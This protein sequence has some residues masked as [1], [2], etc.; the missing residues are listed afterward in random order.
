MR[1]ILIS[2][3]LLICISNAYSQNTALEDFQNSVSYNLLIR[4]VLM[5]GKII[6]FD[7][8]KVIIEEV[9]GNTITVLH[10][11][12]Q[13]SES[14]VNVGR[15]LAIKKTSKKYIPNDHDYALAFVDFTA[16]D[17]NST[18]VLTIYD[19]NWDNYVASR[20]SLINGEIS[21]W[22]A[23]GI[24]DEIKEKYGRSSGHFCDGNK[25]GDVSW[26]ECYNCMWNTCQ[27]DPECKNLCDFADKFGRPKNQCKI[28]IAASCVW[29]A[30][31][32]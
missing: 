24:P 26:G 16:V 31:V 14:K 22:T 4:N 32:Y 5:E 1:K 28:S 13:N 12:I 18:G 23:N 27:N 30:A 6:N 21:E 11:F 7:S 3:F 19:I 25:N 10:L 29:L 15:I 17:K 8:S 9:N 20:I 2:I